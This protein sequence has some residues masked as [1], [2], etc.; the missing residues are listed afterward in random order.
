MPRSEQPSSPYEE[1]AARRRW[2]GPTLANG[3][4]TPELAQFCQ[5]GISIVLG[6]C[7]RDRHPVVG[8]GL[9]CAVDGNGLVRIV[10]RK[11]SNAAVLQSVAGGAGVAVTFTRPRDH[12]SIQLKAASAR[13]AAAGPQDASL[14][15]AQTMGFVTE[16]TNVGYPEAFATRYCAFEAGDLAAL[17]FVPQD[18]FVQTPGP[19]AGSALQP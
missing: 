12:R 5:S 15:A 14:A 17:E 1:L 6:S 18:A 8:R 9:G 4:L 10:L 7:D 16:L 2:T 11:S 19:R 3:V 13:L